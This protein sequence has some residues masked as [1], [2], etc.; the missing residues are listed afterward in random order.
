MTLQD[1]LALRTGPLAL[2][3]RNSDHATLTPI[4]MAM[5]IQLIANHGMEQLRDLCVVDASQAPQCAHAGGW[6]RRAVFG[7][8][9]HIY[10][11]DAESEAILTALLTRQAP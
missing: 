7:E 3:E 6:N 5:R 8:S 2:T 11:R 9:V 1:F 4:T 10:L